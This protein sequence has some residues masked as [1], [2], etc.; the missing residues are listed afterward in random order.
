MTVKLMGEMKGL[1][2]HKSE[3]PLGCLETIFV[4]GNPRGLLLLVEERH[5][6]H[7]SATGTVTLLCDWERLPVHT[8]AKAHVEGVEF[9]VE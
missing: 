1:N 3:Q 8:W 6:C 5:F 7:T 2:P 9:G 4:F